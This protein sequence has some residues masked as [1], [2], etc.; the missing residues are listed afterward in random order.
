M[1][2]VH[3]QLEGVCARTL[4]SFLYYRIA[5]MP[6][7]SKERRSDPR[8]RAEAFPELKCPAQGMCSRTFIN[9]AALKIH[10]NHSKHDLPPFCEPGAHFHRTPSGFERRLEQNT[11]A[12]QEVNPP[13]PMTRSEILG[14]FVCFRWPSAQYPANVILR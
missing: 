14:E 12:A 3:Y 9:N 2:E 8:F 1:W 5:I 6:R 4:L 10:L 11:L 7:A 13:L